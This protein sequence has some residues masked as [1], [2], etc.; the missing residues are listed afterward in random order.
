MPMNNGFPEQ[1]AMTV[2]FHVGTGFYLSLHKS[3]GVLGM[4]EVLDVQL[5]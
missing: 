1:R 2:I 5:S 3:M 4:M